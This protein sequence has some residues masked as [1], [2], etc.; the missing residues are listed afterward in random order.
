MKIILTKAPVGNDVL[1]WPFGAGPGM[2]TKLEL[3]P[4]CPT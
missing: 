4:P 1:L 3:L 2:R